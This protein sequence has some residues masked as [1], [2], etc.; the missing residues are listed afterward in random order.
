MSDIDNILDAEKNKKVVFGA[1][2]TM[3]LLK[4]NALSE[5]YLSENYPSESVAIID[6]LA[7]EAKVKVH[8]LKHSNDE[9]GTLCKKPFKIAVIG[10]L[11]NK[12]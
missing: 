7:E 11:K 6:A 10:I 2:Q 8:K 5:I 4:N 12:E 3:K 9:L 1:N